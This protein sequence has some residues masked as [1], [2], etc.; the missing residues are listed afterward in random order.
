M[1][2][3]LAGCPGLAWSGLGWAGLSGCLCALRVIPFP[4]ASQ[5]QIKQRRQLLLGSALHIYAQ[6]LCVSLYIQRRAILIYIAFDL[7]IYRA[8]APPRSV[9]FRSV[10]FQDKGMRR[11][12]PNVE[13]AQIT[14]EVLTCVCYIQTYYYVYMYRCV[15]VCIVVAVVVVVVVVVALHTQETAERCKRTSAPNQFS[16]CCLA[17]AT[18][19]AA[20]LCG[21]LSHALHLH[22]CR[23]WADA[24]DA[25]PT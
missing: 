8:L 10:Q 18:S 23:S 7:R 12:R 4:P 16:I 3:W 17:S 21:S 9:P 25:W 19:T 11:Q 6:I 20:P 22:S 2:D 24:K 1:A 14:N 13:V 5:S 15:S